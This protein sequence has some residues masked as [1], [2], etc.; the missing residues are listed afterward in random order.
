MPATD[1]YYT[2]NFRPSSFSASGDAE[3]K[4][5]FIAQNPTPTGRN[6]ARANMNHMV[7]LFSEFARSHN[8]NQDTGYQWDE[9]TTPIPKL[10]LKTPPFNGFAYLE[11]ASKKCW[12]L[13]TTAIA[14]CRRAS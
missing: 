10:L 8:Q 13:F 3:G 14:F 2:P 4:P 6:I 12:C 5:R 7:C 11:E 9:A 1:K